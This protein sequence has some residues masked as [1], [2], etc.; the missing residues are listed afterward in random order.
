MEK[1]RQPIFFLEYEH[2]DITAYVTPFLISLT[3]T[4]HEHGQSDE[5]DLQLEDRSALWKSIWYPR[6]ADRLRLRIGYDGERLLECGRFRID[7]LEMSGP[8]DTI[9]LKALA[10]GIT[11]ALRQEN[12]VAYE[13]QSLLDIAKEIA[14]KHGLTVVTNP[15]TP[16]SGIDTVK[17]T[18]ITQYRERDLSF[19]KRLAEDYG[20]IFRIS[21][22]TLTFYEREVLESGG[23]I[24][25]I[26]RSEISSYNFKD[27]TEGTYESCEVSYHDPET[28][29]LI[30]HT[31]HEPQVDVVDDTTD[32]DRP[33][34]S[35]VKVDTHKVKKR[36]ENKW[37]A[38]KKAKAHL[39]NANGRAC[40]ATIVL[41]GNPR[42]VAG[43]NITLTGFHVL[44]GTYHVMTSKH[45]ITRDGGYPTEL[46]MKR[47]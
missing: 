10:T 36:V 14:A 37:Q 18:R 24:A 38:I 34:T 16:E 1:V 29:T 13:H 12:T 21:D 5:I 27:K 20:Y 44:D 42:L 7:E 19:L 30:S 3:Y 25:V 43:S 4:D 40:D 9:H 31:E 35:I 32:K 41:P 46:E 39:A 17:V 33:H 22:A 28:K 11:T 6:K 15:R 2:K 8:P 47:V 23:V 26:D 45:S